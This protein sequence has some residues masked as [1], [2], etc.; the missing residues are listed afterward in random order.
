MHVHV[1]S[2]MSKFRKIFFFVNCAKNTS[3]R[4]GYLEDCGVITKK[5]MNYSLFLF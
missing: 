4:L 1:A 3:A 5:Q 2:D